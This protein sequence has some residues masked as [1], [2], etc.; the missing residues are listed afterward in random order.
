MDKLKLSVISIAVLL[1]I[2]VLIQNSA[3]VSTRF[4]FWAIEAPQ[5]VWVAI[6]FALGAVAGYFVGRKTRI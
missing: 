6:L 1:V 3:T 4:L 5:F 2:V